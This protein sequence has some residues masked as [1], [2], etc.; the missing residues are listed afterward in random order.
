MTSPT[1]PEPPQPIPPTPFAD[2]DVIVSRIA[3]QKSAWSATSIEK[4]IDYLKKC[5]AGTAAVADEW[6][7]GGCRLKG[8][9]ENDSLVGEE[10]LAGPWQTAR[11]IRL[12]IEALEH[13]GQPKAKSIKKRDDGRTV[14]RVFPQSIFDRLLFTGFS[15]E[16]WLEPNAEA[17]QGAIYRDAKSGTPKETKVALVL[18]AGNVSSIAPMDALYKLFVENEIPILKMN[19]VNAVVGPRIFL[20][21]FM[22]VR[23]SATI[24]RTIRRSKRCTSPAPTRRTTRSFGVPTKKSRSGVRRKTIARTCGSSARSSGA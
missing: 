2:I 20:R 5:M 14:A 7:K 21:W 16:I 23:R 4:R 13:D 8:I 24:S 19:P 17:T 11:N 3:S 18:G 22:A 9:D 6:V 1:F 10:W 15:G 12:L